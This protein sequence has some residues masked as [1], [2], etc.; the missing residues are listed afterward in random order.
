MTSPEVSAEFVTQ[1]E[2]MSQ[3]EQLLALRDLL[4]GAGSSPLHLNTS[5]WILTQGWLCGIS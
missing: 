2:Q 1:I 4:T 3:Q 5:L